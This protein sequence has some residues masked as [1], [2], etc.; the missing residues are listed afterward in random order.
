MGPRQRDQGAADPLRLQSRRLAPHAR[1][2]PVPGL[3]A[4]KRANLSDRGSSTF[5]KSKTRRCNP[6]W[7]ISE[8][9]GVAGLDYA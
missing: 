8:M 5:A 6:F 4:D 9:C 7:L 3:R 1:N 2:I